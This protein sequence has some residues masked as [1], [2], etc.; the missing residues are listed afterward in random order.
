[1]ATQGQKEIFMNFNDEQLS[2]GLYHVEVKS[3]SEIFH[4]KLIYQKIN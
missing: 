1:M 4:N 2:S 3:G